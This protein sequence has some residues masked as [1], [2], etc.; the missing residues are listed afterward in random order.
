MGSG[1]LTFSEPRERFRRTN[2]NAVEDFVTVSQVVAYV[3]SLGW[4]QHYRIIEYLQQAK[5]T[6]CISSNF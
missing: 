5:D 6:L 3:K 1:V 4:T 2:E